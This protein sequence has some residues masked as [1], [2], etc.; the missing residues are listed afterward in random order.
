MALKADR[1]HVDSRIDYFMTHTAERGGVVVVQ[2]GGSGIAMDQ[3]AHR[4]E[5]SITPSGKKPVGV[6]MSQVVNLDLTR[7]KM[8]VHKEEVQV[9]GKVTIWN[10]CQV[11]TNYVQ[12]GVSPT[13]GQTA[14]LHREGRF[15]N[16]DNIG[17]APTVG[18]F[19]S[20]K[21]EDGY[22]KVSVNLP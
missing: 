20:K 15:T 1:I 18:V 3:G 11:T 13:A 2:N 10:K 19:D 12:S 14:Y 8:N 9:G 7:Q 17:G 6:L 22:V 5:Y 4:V 16:V 21:D